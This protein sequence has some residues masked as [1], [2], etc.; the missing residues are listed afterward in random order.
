MFFFFVGLICGILLAQEVPQVPQL[1][2]F[3]VRTI[4]RFKASA[5]ADVDAADAPSDSGDKVD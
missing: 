5:N 3:I 2:P 1:K 4:D